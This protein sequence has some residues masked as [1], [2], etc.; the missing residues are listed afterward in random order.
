M[1]GKTRETFIKRQKE[2]A[3]QEKQRDKIAKR[4]QRRSERPAGAASLDNIDWTNSSHG[5]PGDDA[6]NGDEG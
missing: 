5:R 6:S 3:R 4:Q 1:G 2:R